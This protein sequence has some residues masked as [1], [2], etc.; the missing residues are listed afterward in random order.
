MPAQISIDGH[1]ACGKST[2]AQGLAGRLGFLYIDSGAMY[3][4]VTLFFLENNISFD[5]PV[6]PDKIRELRLDFDHSDPSDVRLLLNGKDVTDR[7]RSQEINAQVSIV[8]AMPAVRKRLVELQQSYGRENDVVMDGRDIG[9]TV[10]PDAALKIFLTADIE[11][12]TKR[13]MLDQ[14]SDPASY[15]SIKQNLLHRDHI[16]STRQDSPLR[17]APDAVLLDNSN[18]TIRE[19]LEM[20]AVLAG[21]RLEDS[22]DSE[23][24]E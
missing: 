24:S 16:D 5:H 14:K 4:G 15:E 18:L 17:K 3:R 21:L 19:Q 11:T 1:S 10:F 20:T 12:R 6:T 13:R 23:I 8:A 7:L 9:T 22:S 2:L